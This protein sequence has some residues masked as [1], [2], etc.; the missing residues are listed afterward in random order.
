MRGTRRDKAKAPSP[1]SPTFPKGDSG[2]CCGMTRPVLVVVDLQRYYLEP[3]GDFRRFTEI[4]HP[5]AFAYI[6][7]RCQDLVLPNVARLLDHF[8][9]ASWPVLFLRLCGRC[10]DRSDLHRFFRRSHLRAAR[11]GYPGFYPL[12]HEP[13]A[14]VH[15]AIAPAPAEFVFDKVTFSGFTSSPLQQALEDLEAEVLVFCGLATSQCVDTTARDASER[16]FEVVHVEDA[17][18]DYDEVMHRASLVA[19]RAVCG[20]CIVSTRQV[21]RAR[22]PADLISHRD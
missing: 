18:A 4:Y 13:L 15:P 9:R 17:Q 12:S 19:S 2:R 21:L 20:G 8:R 5:D 22:H 6:A 11:A 16:G 14:E 3:G 7:G 10:P 1:H